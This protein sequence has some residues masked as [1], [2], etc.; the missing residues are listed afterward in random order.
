MFCSM[1]EVNIHVLKT[2]RADDDTGKTEMKMNVVQQLSNKEPG[3]L[4]NGSPNESLN[5]SQVYTEHL[6]HDI[7]VKN[8]FIQ[9][10]T[11]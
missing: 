2:R 1:K 3:K 9:S 11:V 10:C 8:L 4:H 6:F 7:I 5:C